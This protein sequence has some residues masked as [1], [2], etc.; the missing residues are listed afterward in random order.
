MVVFK[1]PN[2]VELKNFNDSSKFYNHFE[3]STSL[4]KSLDKD[5][6]PRYSNIR[7]T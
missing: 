5:S 2:A 4:T 7:L 1:P 6:K 3:W